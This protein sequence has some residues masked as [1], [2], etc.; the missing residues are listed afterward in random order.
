MHSVF[1]FFFFV[2]ITAAQFENLAG[3]KAGTAHGRSAWRG[4]RSLN[5][6]PSPDGE[7]QGIQDF[8]DSQAFLGILGDDATP[9]NQMM[10]VA[11]SRYCVSP[12]Y[13]NYTTVRNT[14]SG[15]QPGGCSVSYQHTTHAWPLLAVSLTPVVSHRSL[16]RVE[17]PKGTPPSGGP[18]SFPHTTPTLHC[19]LPI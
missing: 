13:L 6:S 16:S 9:S 7:I 19:K 4:K 14:C 10:P 18:T 5:T 15:Q 11:D 17:P 1:F 2:V 8:Q 3:C 12:K